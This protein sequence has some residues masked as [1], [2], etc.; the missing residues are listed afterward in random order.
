VGGKGPGALLTSGPRPRLLRD[1]LDGRL[2]RPG[3]RIVTFSPV[4]VNL[5]QVSRISG[6]TSNNIPGHVTAPRT[7][8]CKGDFRKPPPC[9][10]ASGLPPFR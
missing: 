8:A 1:G 6:T 4:V 5:G 10:R 7:T 2:L 9:F 3:L